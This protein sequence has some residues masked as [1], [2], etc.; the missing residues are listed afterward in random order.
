MDP[1]V[2]S[3]I[4]ILFRASDERYRRARRVEIAVL[5]I[6]REYEAC[7]FSITPRRIRQS[8]VLSSPLSLSLGYRSVVGLHVP[9]CLLRRDSLI[10]P[11]VSP[12][13]FARVS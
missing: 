3:A 8:R 10:L 6:L 7:D 11:R 4:G 12:P 2:F 9:K 5:E 1:A 13:L